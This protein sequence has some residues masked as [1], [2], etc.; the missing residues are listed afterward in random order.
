M[1]HIPLKQAADEYLHEDID[2][3]ALYKAVYAKF[4]RNKSLTNG[5]SKIQDSL[6][7]LER[8][9]EITKEATLVLDSQ[10]SDKLKRLNILEAEL[11]N[12]VKKARFISIFKPQEIRAA[13]K[14]LTHVDTVEE[15]F[16][17][18]K[19]LY[20]VIDNC[21]KTM[22]QPLRDALTKLKDA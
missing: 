10:D 19:K 5:I 16:I 6:S 9:S 12:E 13:L 14:E 4:D 22:Q 7:A 18:S 2:K 11:M 1:N 20:A 21:Y 3:E 17:A 15:S 8:C